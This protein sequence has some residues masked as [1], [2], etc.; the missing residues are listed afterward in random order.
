MSQKTDSTQSGLLEKFRNRYETDRTLRLRIRK[1]VAAI[2]LML[3][4]VWFLLPFLWTLKTSLQ[5]RPVAQHYPPIL[6]GFE[7]QWDN[8]TNV[9]FQSPFYK[10]LRNG[11]IV[12]AATTVVA[13]LFAVP[14]A[15]AISKFDYTIRTPS[16]YLVL[17]VRVFPLVALAVPFYL[18]YRQL[19]L[20]NTKLGLVIVLTM[21]YIPFVVWIMK[22]FFDGISSSV[23]EAARMDGCSNFQAFYR[24]MLPLATP[25]LAS[26]II[27]TWLEAFNHFTLVFFLT[28]SAKAQTVPF[29]IL[30]FVR[31]NFVPWNIISAA[32]L[33]GMV[34]SIIV[35]VLF[36]KYLVRGIT[37]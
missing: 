30:S 1:G 35:V 10:Y 33:L 18:L 37:T 17:A 5:T 25:A 20:I 22:S 26:S 21:L 13:M 36:Q 2:T 24:V 6:W 14:H 27:F 8:Y 3:L 16:M 23:I 15:Y 34:P 31:D 12:S 29:G 11:I 28:A 9:L 7:L 4:L 19:G 32:A